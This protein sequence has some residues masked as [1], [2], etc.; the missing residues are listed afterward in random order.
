MLNFNLMYFQLGVYM[1]RNKNDCD[2]RLKWFIAFKDEM[3]EEKKI[4][5]F[6]CKIGFGI[7]YQSMFVT[8]RTHK[9]SALQQAFCFL[10]FFYSFLKME[11]CSIL[12]SFQSSRC[13]SA[14]NINFTMSKKKKWKRWKKGKK[15]HW[16]FTDKLRTRSE[17][18]KLD[19]DFLFLSRF[20][21]SFSFFSSKNIFE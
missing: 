16:E 6:R 18:I 21:P 13:A 11:K 12:N 7:R 20:F 17:D 2:G 5:Y 4:N 14:I 1:F 8:N 10:L 19:M 3:K 9:F 15:N